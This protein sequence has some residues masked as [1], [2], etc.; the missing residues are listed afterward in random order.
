MYRFQPEAEIASIGIKHKQFHHPIE[1][2]AAVEIQLLACRLKF[3]REY[4]QDSPS[5]PEE[6]REN[7]CWQSSKLR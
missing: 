3:L 7:F 2:L 6:Y 1:V 4:E 5:K